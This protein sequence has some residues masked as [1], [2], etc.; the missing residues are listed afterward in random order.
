MPAA[1]SISRCA[2]NQPLSAFMRVRV[3]ALL[4]V[5]PITSVA[6]KKLQA[7]PLTSELPYSLESR[8]LNCA[9]PS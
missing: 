7:S 3:P 8:F 5:H 2:L 9:K 1:P 4:H 6:Q